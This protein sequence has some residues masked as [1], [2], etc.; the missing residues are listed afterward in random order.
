VPFI[1]DDGQSI[2]SYEIRLEGRDEHIPWHISGIRR[3]DLI[4][5]SRLLTK[6]LENRR[7][8]DYCR[9]PGA[10]W[11]ESEYSLIIPLPAWSIPNDLAGIK[12]LLNGFKQTKGYGFV[13]EL[14]I[15]PLM[16]DL[17]TPSADIVENLKESLA[18]Y[19]P[20]GQFAKSEN[21]ICLSL[22]DI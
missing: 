8:Y 10:L 5:S 19:L 3:P 13:R 17:T 21:I 14:L 11:Y 20:I 9:F 18:R 12:P 1:A 4:A 15:L 22:E 6:L 16:H 7:S 2:P